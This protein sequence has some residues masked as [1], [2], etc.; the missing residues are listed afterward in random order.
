MVP[1]RLMMRLT[2]ELSMGMMSPLM[3]PFQPLRMP[4]HSIPRPTAERTTA[5]MQAFMPGASPPLVSTPILFTAF[6]I[7]MTPFG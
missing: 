5:R 7:F 4:T 3:R 6:S 2:L 1:P